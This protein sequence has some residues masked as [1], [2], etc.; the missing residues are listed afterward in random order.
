MDVSLGSHQRISGA[1][2]SA[3]DRHVPYGN[4]S[5]RVDSGAQPRA[6]AYAT[7]LVAVR[8]ML[9]PRGRWSVDLDGRECAVSYETLEGARRV[10]YLH[11]ARRRPSELIIH[12]AY[13][14]VV[15]REFIPGGGCD[16]SGAL[17]RTL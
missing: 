3:H 5:R 15:E 17:R 6:E 1:G 8:I 11:A 7:R 16:T 9:S 10:A 14:R 4:R 2:A 12:D 13:H